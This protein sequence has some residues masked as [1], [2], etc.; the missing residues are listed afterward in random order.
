MVAHFWVGW[1]LSQPERVCVFALTE[2]FHTSSYCLQEESSEGHGTTAETW[3][4]TAGGHRGK[5]IDVLYSLSAITLLKEQIH[6]VR[7]V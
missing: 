5:F 1:Y 3:R 4:V 2:R 7:I 6:C